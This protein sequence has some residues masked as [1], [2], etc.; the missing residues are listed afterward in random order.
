MTS[1]HRYSEVRSVEE[2]MDELQEGAG[3]RYDPKLV[4]IFTIAWHNGS[5]KLIAGDG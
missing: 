5:V 4:K 3:T 1:P 2:A